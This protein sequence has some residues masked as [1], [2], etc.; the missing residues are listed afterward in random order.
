MTENVHDVLRIS[1]QLNDFVIKYNSIIIFLLEKIIIIRP[2][3]F[4]INTIIVNL[5]SIL[6]SPRVLILQLK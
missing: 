4:Y 1:K 6:H 2:I 5:Q 3:R